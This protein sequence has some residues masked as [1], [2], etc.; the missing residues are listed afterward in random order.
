MFSNISRLAFRRP[1]LGTPLLTKQFTPIINTPSITRLLK[2]TAAAKAKGRP[3]TIFINDKGHKGTVPLNEKIVLW[4]I[5]GTFNRHNTRCTVVAVVE[6]LDF[7]EK[8][9]D[10]S[11]NEKVL[12]YMQLPHKVKYSVTGGNLGYKKSARQEY[13]VG[14]QVAAKLFQTIQERNLIG[15]SDKVELILK[16]YGKG[17]EAFKAALMGKEGSRIKDLVVRV[18]DA[19]VLK[20]GGNR[21]KKLRRL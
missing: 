8:N 11:Y 3:E 1:A 4:K 7:M 18:S 10:L 17:R 2:T 9:K 15:P 19:T 21:A 13:E 5:Y 6:D 12:Y 20:F 14:F 16:N